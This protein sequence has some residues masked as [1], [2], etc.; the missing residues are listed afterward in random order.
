MGR[1]PVRRVERDPEV[2]LSPRAWP[3]NLAPVAQLLAEGLE[4]GAATILVGENG[5]GKSTLVEGIA[6]AYGLSPEGGSTGAQHSTRVS[7]SPLAGSLRLTRRPGTT[8]WGYFLRAETMHGLFTYLEHNPPPPSAGEPVFHEQ[9]HGE[10]FL[11]MITTS[12]FA[13]GGF[14][15]LDEP[16]AG[17]SF[18][19]QLT[20]VGVLHSMINSGEAQVLLATHSPIIAALPSARLLELDENGMHER[21]WTNSTWSITT[22]AS[23]IIR[24]SICGGCSTEHH[25]GALGHVSL[26]PGRLRGA[27]DATGCVGDTPRTCSLRCAGSRSVV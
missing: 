12:R 1:R 22:A 16:E 10:S 15:V 5:T 9:S 23:L 21:A 11:S 17:L 20:L 7:E 25:E 2:V 6:S 19:A 26:N 4:L 18:T 8:R 27:Q 14:F 3:A 24:I 13:R